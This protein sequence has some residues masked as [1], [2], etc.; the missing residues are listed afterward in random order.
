VRRCPRRLYRDLPTRFM[1]IGDNPTVVSWAG[2]VHRK[3]SHAQYQILF[4]LRKGDILI[5][6]LCWYYHSMN[7]Y[8]SGSIRGGRNDVELYQQVIALLSRYGAVLTEFIGDHS[9]TV[10][11]TD[12]TSSEIFEKDMALLR[13][14]DVLVAEVTVPSLGVGYEVAMAETMGK[15]VLCLYRPSPDRKL[16]AML[17]GNSALYVK[18]YTALSDLTP[19]LEK[20]FA[21]YVLSVP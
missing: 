17:A 11:G 5:A 12:A 8:F 6:W 14:S 4:V 18:E 1:I 3:L 16:S 7:I 20:F 10:M 15:P 2:S 19:L 9:L 13:A 21:M